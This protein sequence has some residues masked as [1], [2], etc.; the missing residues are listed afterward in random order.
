MAA[1]EVF[2]LA[3]AGDAEQWRDY[4]GRRTDA[5]LYHREHWRGI[6]AESFG[7]RVRYL[8]ARSHGRTCGV[9]PLFEMR[10]WLFGHFLVSL[11]FVNYGGILADSPEHADALAS[12]AIS[13]A[14]ATG[15]RHVEIRQTGD[16]LALDPDRWQL[17]QHKAALV[18][19][20]D[21]GVDAL[22][23]G[24]ASRLRGK[25]RKAG[26][27]GAVFSVND[28]GALGDFHRVFAL[29]MRN[30]GTPTH[31]P[32]FFDNVLRRQDG[33]RLLLVHR[34]GQPVAG[35]LALRAGHRLEL[36]W[37]CS[38]YAHAGANVNEYL[39]WKAIEWAVE[40]GARELDL[41]RSSFDA[42]TFRFK[43]Q[44]NPAVRPLSWYYWLAA[45]D[46]LPELNPH[47][48]RYALAVRCWKRLPVAVANMAGPAIV[49][50][51][52]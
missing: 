12:A 18:V 25:I 21:E 19:E 15:A 44:W 11:P 2:E 7:H 14:R 49:R 48:P 31:G 8:M 3:S 16:Q 10:S 29:N 5:A 42:G 28:A 41:G 24:L 23:A 45:G 17:R 50:N 38:D 37:I 47:N 51:I 6:L 34:D 26:K 33:A 46:K 20:L 39:Y 52:P 13:L 36:P 32:A 27:S 43:K 35:A 4:I 40:T 1:T 22:W 30:L 9:L